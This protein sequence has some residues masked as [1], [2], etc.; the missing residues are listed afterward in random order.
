M[1]N[2][3]TLNYQTLT[4]L[5]QIMRL[6]LLTHI[7]CTRPTAQKRALSVHFTLGELR[8]IYIQMYLKYVQ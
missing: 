2:N 7:F 6:Y 4:N 3:S 5:T 1:Q 8:E